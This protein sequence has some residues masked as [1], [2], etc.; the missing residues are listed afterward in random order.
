MFSRFTLLCGEK[1]F[2]PHVALSLNLTSIIRR[3]SADVTDECEPVF[4]STCLIT[5]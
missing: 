1:H 4:L 3:S 2:S 5:V